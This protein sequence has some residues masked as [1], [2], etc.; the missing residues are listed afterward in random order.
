MSIF[1]IQDGRL[2]RRQRAINIFSLFFCPVSRF[3]SSKWMNIYIFHSKPFQPFPFEVCLISDFVLKLK[4]I[5]IC[6]F[7]LAFFLHLILYDSPHDFDF[8]LFFELDWN[9]FFVP[10]VFQAHEIVSFT[11]DCQSLSKESKCPRNPKHCSV[12]INIILE[13]ALIER[14]EVREHFA[15]VNTKLD[16]FSTSTQLKQHS[17][18]TATTNGASNP[19]DWFMCL[20][21]AVNLEAD[22]CF[23]IWLKLN[24]TFHEANG[25]GHSIPVHTS[26]HSRCEMHAA[27]QTQMVCLCIAICIIYILCNGG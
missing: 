26:T 18:I 8:G 10:C 20:W 27:L 7:A 25:H 5:A 14:D 22:S 24:L 23:S 19:A 1:E 11:A 13:R 3:G 17:S 9:F 6:T 4:C 2:K 12:Y 16:K 15:E 21:P